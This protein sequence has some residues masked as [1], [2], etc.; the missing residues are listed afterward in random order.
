MSDKLIELARECGASSTPIWGPPT[1]TFTADQLATFRARVRAEAMEEL[2]A[3]AKSR[4]DHEVAGAAHHFRTWYA[5]Y[6]YHIDRAKG[7]SDMMDALRSHIEK[8]AKA[9]VEGALK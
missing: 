7:M 4:Y 3:V 6:E 2:L 9:G 8:T 5:G 1:V